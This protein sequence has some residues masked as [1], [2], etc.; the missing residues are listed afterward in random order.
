MENK[1]TLKRAEF[2]GTHIEACR[3]GGLTVSAYCKL[4]GL[5][6][7][8]YYYWQKRLR[9]GAGRKSA[10]TELQSVKIPTTAVTVRYPNGVCIEFCGAVDLPVLKELVCCI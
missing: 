2:M 6:P 4:H 8:N 7:S 3:S 1:D 10:F 5:L 9:S